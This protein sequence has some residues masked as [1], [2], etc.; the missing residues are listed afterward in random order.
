MRQDFGG[1][2]GGAG[3]NRRGRRG[4]AVFPPIACMLSRN[5]TWLRCTIPS[6]CTVLIDAEW[7]PIQNQIGRSWS[8][9]VASICRIGSLN[10]GPRVDM[11]FR[12]V[13]AK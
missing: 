10:S 6:S 9:A 4:F 12:I 13:P 2:T 5:N 7:S 3:S 11:A 8:L 1:R